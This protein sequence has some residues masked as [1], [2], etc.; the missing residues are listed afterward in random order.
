MRV[1]I[2][3][4]ITAGEPMKEAKSLVQR[5]GA[6]CVYEGDIRGTTWCWVERDGE[7]VSNL[8]NIDAAIETARA[9]DDEDGESDDWDG[10]ED[11]DD[12]D[13]DDE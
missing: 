1:W 6:Y 4:I 11:E 9:L 12:E 2:E 3:Q 7:R 13:S 8:G 5:I 10:D